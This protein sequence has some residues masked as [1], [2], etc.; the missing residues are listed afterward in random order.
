MEKIVCAAIKF[1]R[2]N[3]NFPVWQIYTGLRHADALYRMYLDGIKYDK[4][5][6]IEGFMTTEDRFVDRVEAAKIAFASR[7]IKEPV[8][9]LYSEDIYPEGKEEENFNNLVQKDIE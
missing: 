3:D 9:I 8:A 1:K 7:Q 5:S 2:S 6:H 4:P